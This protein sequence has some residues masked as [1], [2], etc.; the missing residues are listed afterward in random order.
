MGETDADGVPLVSI[1]EAVAEVRRW[2]DVEKVDPE[3]IFTATGDQVVRYKDLIGHLERETPDGQLLRFAISRGRML[4][5]EQ[6]RGPQ[7]LL[8]IGLPPRPPRND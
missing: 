4:R 3:T 5:P 2:L 7:L 8:Q 6:A 1:A